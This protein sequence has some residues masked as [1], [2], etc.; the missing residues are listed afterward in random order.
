MGSL[1]VSYCPG[2]EFEFRI[3]TKMYRFPFKVFRVYIR[4]G[5][6]ERQQATVT[7][8]KAFA[9]GVGAQDSFQ[10]GNMG[11]T[12]GYIRVE[13]SELRT[14][15]RTIV[16]DQMD[17]NIQKWRAYWEWKGVVLPVQGYEVGFYGRYW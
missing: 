6:M 17:A 3:S 7:F 8:S 9:E 2:M 11:V 12:Y 10:K 15:M 16:K 5:F 14:K 1:A 4:F 13:G